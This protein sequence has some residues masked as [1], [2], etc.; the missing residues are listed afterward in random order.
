MALTK[1]QNAMVGNSS[2]IAFTPVVPIIEN[3]Q[4][5]TS[6]YTITANNEVLS[7]LDVTYTGLET[8][9]T[10]EEITDENNGP[11]AIEP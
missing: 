2:S 4:N 6:A 7:V 9:T 1:I 10:G 8:E 3:T 5:V 11:L